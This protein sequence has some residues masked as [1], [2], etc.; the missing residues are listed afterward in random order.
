VRDLR[1]GLAKFPRCIYAYRWP[2][3]TEF[4]AYWRTHR[5]SEAVRAAMREAVRQTG[6]LQPKTL[7][8]SSS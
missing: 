8:Q 3:G 6:R 1:P 4:S 2:N 5:L 7:A